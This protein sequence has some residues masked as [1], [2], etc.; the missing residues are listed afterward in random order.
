MS[1]WI[2]CILDAHVHIQRTEQREINKI[3]ITKLL[4]GRWFLLVWTGNE[5]LIGCVYVIKKNTDKIVI[6]NIIIT[7]V[8]DEQWE[9]SV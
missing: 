9:E 8:M 6:I 7:A 1:D 5:E 3:S 4:F 2:A